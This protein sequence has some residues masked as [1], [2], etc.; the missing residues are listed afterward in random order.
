VQDGVQQPTL[1]H[2]RFAQH[3]C[4]PAHPA[5][6]PVGATEQ[7]G[8]LV[9]APDEGGMEERVR[10]MGQGRGRVHGGRFLNGLALQPA[11]P[12][13]GGQGQVGQR[14]PAAFEHGQRLRAPAQR[15]MAAHEG[16]G[17]LLV[18]RVVFQRHGPMGGGA[19][20]IP[21]RV[22]GAGQHEPGPLQALAPSGQ[23]ALEPLF[24][25][26]L[27]QQIARAMPES[28]FE[29][30]RGSAPVL[31]I[32]R[33]FAPVE[34]GR[35]RSKVGFEFG[36]IRQAVAAAAGTH[37]ARAPALRQV[38][39]EREAQFAHPAAQVGGRTLDGSVRPKGRGELAGRAG[40]A[41]FEREQCQQRLC[42]VRL[43]NLVVQRARLPEHAEAS[44]Q[45]DAQAVRGSLLRGSI[46]RRQTRPNARFSRRAGPVRC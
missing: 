15:E 26:V 38:R 18:G 11:Q 4:H 9:P 7:A 23:R 34:V 43:P 37:V 42:L 16:P 39:F 44:Q 10:G 5:E 28:R 13:A 40:R 14:R 3:G 33:P 8:A 36:H 25:I 6:R 1:A 32:E 20:W 17:D 45:F 12:H 30:L 35:A 19:P 2:A 41:R 21:Q 46:A 24:Q 27:G 31:P 22:V 29:G